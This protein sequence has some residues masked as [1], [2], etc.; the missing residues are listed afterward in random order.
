MEPEATDEIQ[1]QPQN[2]VTE[3]AFVHETTIASS[4]YHLW[5]ALT[6]GELTRRYWFDRRIE[7]DWTFGSPVRFYAGDSQTLTD[8]GEVVAAE[9]PRLLSY[10]FAPVGYPASRVSF[11]LDPAA[12]GVT[13]RLVHDQL[14]RPDDVEAWREGWTPILANL[15]A[16]LEA[17]DPAVPGRAGRLLRTEAAALM[18]LLR[19]QPAEAFDTP[20]A[21]PGW[22]VRDVLAHCSAALGHAA[23][24]T[25]HDFNP[26]S[27]QRDVDVRKGWPVADLLDELA[28][29]YV[30]GA[31]AIDGAGGRL[32]ALGLGEWVHGGDVRAALGLPWAY[33]SAG[34]AD[35]LVLLGARSRTRE[36]PA[37]DVVLSDSPLPEGSLRLGPPE[38]TATATMTT[39]TATLLR[40]CAG[41]SADPAAY[42]LTG[43]DPAAYLMF[44]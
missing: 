36:V 39:D 43:A 40:L 28:A 17:G 42:T 11:E 14:A 25:L 34:V 19:A 10:T 29:G 33:T 32:D 35:A 15:Q 38:G 4:P 44:G 18:P 20:T 30:G 24:G 23:A 6:T 41:R 3:A 2:Q 31:A 27:N 8:I 26:E 5:Q 1:S 16:F 12:E 37:T 9:P 7:S 21:L 22:S 13:L